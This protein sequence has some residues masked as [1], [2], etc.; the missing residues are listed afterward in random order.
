[1]KTRL[2]I[3]A[4]GVVY[5]RHEGRIDV[6]LIRPSGADT[7]Q[8]PKGLVDPGEAV[9]QAAAREVREETGLTA[10]PERRLTRIEYWYTAD[11]SG[12][13]LHKGDIPQGEPVRV[14]KLVYFFLFRVTGGS[15]TAHDAEVTEA[16]WVPLSD[17]ES[18]LSFEN[19]RRVVAEA[20]AALAA[21]GA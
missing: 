14:H 5:R 20:R 13:P 11:A 15:T 17:A 4:G 16:R 10:E 2:D 12:R 9:E 3:S 19:E 6:C 18:M 1:M 21:G 8:L 7:W